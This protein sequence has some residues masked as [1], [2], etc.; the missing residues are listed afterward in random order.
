MND[1]SHSKSLTM[2][3]AMTPAV[4]PKGDNYWAGVWRRLRRDPTTLVCAGI[5]ALILFLI[6]FAPWIS[7]Y[8]PTQGSMV[9]RLKPVG[10]TGH[11]LGTDELGR[12]ML[13]R[14]EFEGKKSPARIAP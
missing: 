10:F 2:S 1:L 9:R 5:L 11:W 12:D 14:R 8:D 7:P 13:A 3:T 4:I 6:V